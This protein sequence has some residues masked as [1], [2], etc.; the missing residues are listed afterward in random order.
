MRAGVSS[1]PSSGGGASFTRWAREVG[2]AWAVYDTVASIV[3][4]GP[5]DDRTAHAA[6]NAVPA[7]WSHVLALEGCA[8]WLDRERRRRPELEA[9]TA[10]AAALLRE[11]A[12]RSLRN[13]VAA[14][15]QLGEILAIAA[16]LG[17]RVL[18]LKGIAR[19]IAG[20]P[21]G[22][23]TMA[24]IDLLVDGPAA[25]GLHERLQLGLGYEADPRGTPARHLPSLAS[26]GSLPVEIHLRVGDRARPHGLEMWDDARRANIG[27]Y[28]IHVP[29]PTMRLLHTIEHAILVHR[30]A[31]YK[32]R[33]LLDVATA[34]PGSDV[35]AVARYIESH[36]S[37]ADRRAIRTLLAAASDLPSTDGCP[38]PALARPDGAVQ[39][40]AWRR[41]RRVARTRL[42][43]PAR[44]DVI[45]ESDPRVLVLSQ[46]AQGSPVV[47]GGLI[48]RAVTA[49]IRAA[50]L[51][52]GS[53]LPAEART[54]ARP[55]ADG[56]LGE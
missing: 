25:S 1:R 5:I 26:A 10:P 45:P 41:V 34:A 18:A 19:L 43:A 7:T 4:G 24:D 52:T 51:V 15:Q 20:E 36:R 22:L 2:A 12:V 27:G 49:P 56:G 8:A 23:R 54:P 30:A 13:G 17:V 33:D 28:E 47:V 50:R 3:A 39:R 9:V 38:T 48:A 37:H 14:A 53:W 29:S 32:L 40:R 42:L 46:I 31:R 11:A 16:E 55:P 21:A 44:A 35:N 6:M